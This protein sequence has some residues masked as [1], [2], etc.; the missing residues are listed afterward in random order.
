MGC[1]WLNP[2][3]CLKSAGSKIKR[4]AEVVGGGIVTVAETAWE[5]LDKAAEAIHLDDVAGVIVDGAEV[6]A[7]FTHMDD[8]AGAIDD[9]VLEPIGDAIE[10]IDDEFLT[11][12]HTK[13]K[14]W[15]KANCTQHGCS[16]STCKECTNIEMERAKFKYMGDL[17]EAEVDQAMAARTEQIKAANDFYREAEKCLQQIK[18]AELALCRSSMELQE[19]WDQ[20]F[21]HPNSA[22]QSPRGDDQA[23]IVPHLRSGRESTTDPGH[24]M[25]YESVA[26]SGENR[27]KIDPRKEGGEQ[28]VGEASSRARLAASLDNSSIDSQV[29][30]RNFGSAMYFIKNI[31]RNSNVATDCGGGENPDG[32]NPEQY[33]AMALCYKNRAVDESAGLD[34]SDEDGTNLGWCTDMQKGHLL[35]RIHPEY[36]ADSY[37]NP[38]TSKTTRTAALKYIFHTGMYAHQHRAFY[39]Q[40]GYSGGI[41]SDG[42]EAQAKLSYYWTPGGADQ[43]QV[44]QFAEEAWNQGVA[45][46]E[47]EGWNLA[48]ATEQGMMASRHLPNGNLADIARNLKAALRALIASNVDKAANEQLLNQ[49]GNRIESA[50]RF[51]TQM[52]NGYDCLSTAANIYNNKTQQYHQKLRS[53]IG[54]GFTDRLG[55]ILTPGN[56]WD[57]HNDLLE[58]LAGEAMDPSSFQG[59]DRQRTI[60]NEQCFLLS[61]ISE[62]SAHKKRRDITTVRSGSVAIS[63]ETAPTPGKGI[64]YVNQA[65]NQSLLLDGDPYGFLNRLTQNGDQKAFFNMKSDIISHLQPKIRLIKVSYDSNNEPWEKE[66]IFD[67]WGTH[68]L[69]AALSDKKQRGFGAGVK[70]FDFAYEGHNPFAVKKSIKAT[71][72]I[73]ANNMKELFEERDGIKYVDLALKTNQ[74]AQSTDDC[75]SGQNGS[76]TATGQHSALEQANLE[77]LN[78]RLKAVVGWAK[79]IGKGPWDEMSELTSDSSRNRQRLR[80]AINNSYTTLN[81]TPTVHN[82][83]FDDMG[84]VIFTIEY[85]AFVDDYYDTPAFNIFAGTDT[86]IQQIIRNLKIENFSRNCKTSELNNIKKNLADQAADE[87]TKALT[88]LIENLKGKKRI[89][90]I[91]LPWDDIA[92]FNSSGP[93]YN[94]TH[95]SGSQFTIESDS[96]N[97]ASMTEEMSKAFES[98]SFDA[99]ANEKEKNV[100]KT[101]LLA[102]TP[103][104]MNLSFFYV[105]DLIDTILESIEKELS[106][107]GTNLSTRL[108]SEG[109]VTSCQRIMAVDKYTR[110]YGNYKKLRILLGPVEFVNQGDKGTNVLGGKSAFVNF[111][112][113]PLSVRYFIEFLSD[114]MLKKDRSTYTLTTFLN[115]MFNKLIKD[116]LNDETCFDWSIKQRVRVNQAV[117]TSYPPTGMMEADEGM[118]EI[119]MAMR[120]K[121]KARLSLS[122]LPMPILRLNGG[123]PMSA[124]D[125]ASEI[126][127]FVYYAGRT[128]PAERMLGNKAED[129]DAGIFHYK[130]GRGEGLI[131]NIK[132]SKTDS[133]GLA[134]VRFEQDG[135]DGLKQLRVVYDTEIDS[136][137]NVKTYPGTYIYVDPLGFAPN[138]RAGGDCSEFGLTDLGIGGYYMIVKSSH[139]FAAGQADSTIYAKWVNGIQNPCMQREEVASEEERNQ[140]GYSNCGTSLATR[141]EEAGEELEI[142]P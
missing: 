59:K 100:F 26:N 37:Q 75:E 128:A 44:G 99:N 96:E 20:N 74:P 45:Q 140:K 102:E 72:K 106:S 91:K 112:D 31:A 15:L 103:E 86:T 115:D 127:Y 121:G 11:S 108:A 24:P 18:E 92:Q 55:N 47:E 34:L 85:L 138:M 21:F 126:N 1:G 111:G 35:R 29:A 63:C 19:I 84:R 66:F 130:L 56:G 22:S 104:M 2:G 82:F 16:G 9:Y 134:E 119:A 78:F 124:G 67:S 23:W 68:D 13:Y 14:R 65:G 94:W 133:R 118:D 107:L 30:A 136:F 43:D 76:Q 139:T 90:Y 54:D 73:F 48:K 17:N 3:G 105:S 10:Y 53:I 58:E 36:F 101:S 7:E 89:Y 57:G 117:L 12:G 87:K 62:I 69:Q 64:P 71:L 95:A 114:Q 4:G 110:A 141:S 51:F 40:L 41:Y 81:L 116:F 83:E 129:E 28:A 46:M 79:P 49:L 39:N 6:V 125:V 50:A 77:K 123:G 27:G 25:W 120:D 8:L 137:A 97:D 52:G 113:V 93:F 60:F 33:G 88:S 38:N 42:W 70:S 61:Y 122:S 135:Y 32:K 5:G 98:Y 132:L 109:D 80:D 142:Q 131:K